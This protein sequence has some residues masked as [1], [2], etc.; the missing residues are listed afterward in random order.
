[1][2]KHPDR[3]NNALVEAFILDGAT[4][5]Y[6]MICTHFN[7]TEVQGRQIDKI[8]QRLRKQGKITKSRHKQFILWTA[9]L[10]TATP[11]TPSDAS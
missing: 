1:M 5:T 9:V 7:A 4:R 2:N 8:I 6:H 11:A 10:S 3:L